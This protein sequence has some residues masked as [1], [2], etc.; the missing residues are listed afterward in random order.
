MLLYSH[1]R[2]ATINLTFQFPFYG[3]LINSIT[4]ATGGFLYLGDYVHSLLAAT[5]YIA[6]LMSLMANFDLSSSN[7]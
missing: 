7:H 5:Q 3:N 4:I 6:P 2:A 1:R